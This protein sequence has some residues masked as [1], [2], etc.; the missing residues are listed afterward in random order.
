MSAR[1]PDLLVKYFFE[2]DVSFENKLSHHLLLT[3]DAELVNDKGITMGTISKEYKKTSSTQDIS[4][5]QALAEFSS[6][7]ME[8]TSS[9]LIDTMHKINTSLPLLDIY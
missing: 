5:Q 1:K 8:M 4:E 2:K 6:D 9:S 7:L 3:A